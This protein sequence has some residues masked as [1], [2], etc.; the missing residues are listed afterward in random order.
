MDMTY[1]RHI[2]NLNAELAQWGL[3]VWSL[4]GNWRLLYL[5]ICCSCLTCF[6][7]K[8]NTEVLR[9][10]SPIIRKS[11]VLRL[12][13]YIHPGISQMFAESLVL[14]PLGTT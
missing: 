3:T 5:R 2:Y 11:S 13:I 10:D 4:E 9:V 12:T 6:L 8:E 7:I 14:A 1:N